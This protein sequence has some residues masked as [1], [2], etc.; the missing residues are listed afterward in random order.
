MPLPSPACPIRA[1]IFPLSLPRFFFARKFR[2]KVSH[3]QSNRWI[4]SFQFTTAV[5]HMPSWFGPYHSTIGLIQSHLASNEQTSKKTECGT[6]KMGRAG[7][8]LKCVVWNCINPTIPDL[9][10]Q[11][12]SMRI[13]G[14]GPLG[15]KDVLKFRHILRSQIIMYET[16]LL[17][18]WFWL[19]KPSMV[20]FCLLYQSFSKLC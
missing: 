8:N 9:W 16:P 7:E 19:W 6:E 4:L 12:I 5:N 20:G 2:W 1:G 11:T 18:L 13:H 15:A 10:E 3:K 14:H 17:H